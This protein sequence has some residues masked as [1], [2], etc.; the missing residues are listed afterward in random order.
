MTS[1]LLALY[2]CNELE[3][4]DTMGTRPC[5]CCL[6]HMM[7]KIY[8]VEL[9]FQRVVGSSNGIV[10]ISWLAEQG[11]RVQAWVSSLQFQRSPKEVSHLNLLM[12]I[13]QA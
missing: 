3:S 1:S 6:N 12:G 13:L 8:N 11:V 5:H 4:A 7:L 2:K 9:P 10:V